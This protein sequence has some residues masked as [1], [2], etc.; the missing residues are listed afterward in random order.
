MKKNYFKLLNIPYSI[1]LEALFLVVVAVVFLALAILPAVIVIV[2][3]QAQYDWGNGVV[4]SDTTMIQ[5]T[6]GAVLASIS[7]VYT[8]YLASR[9]MWL[10]TKKSFVAFYKNVTPKENYNESTIAKFN[11]SYSIKDTFS[12]KAF[13]LSFLALS[14]ITFAISMALLWTI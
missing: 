1:F 12:N 8:T 3:H 14:V 2:P 9:L 13:N 5:Y 11:D 6:I 10:P 7:C 4:L